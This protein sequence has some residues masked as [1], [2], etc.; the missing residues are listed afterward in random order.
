MKQWVG[1]VFQSAV[2]FVSEEDISA[3]TNWSERIK[4]ELAN[5]NIGI[6]CVT[7]ENQDAKWINFEMGALSKAVDGD[8]T[9]VI[10]TLIGF[11][12]LGQ[13]GQPASSFN[14]TMLDHQGLRSIA[15]SLNE[16]IDP[17]MK[18]EETKLA[19]VVDVW[20]GQFEDDF[21]AAIA[22]DPKTTTNVQDESQMIREILGTVR[23]LQKHGGVINSVQNFMYST[24]AS[25]RHDFALTG[26]MTKA[27]AIG[28]ISKYLA[29]NMG[30]IESTLEQKSD[31]VVVLTS[32]KP[33]TVKLQEGLQ[34]FVDRII[35][36]E[37]TFEFQVDP[38]VGGVKS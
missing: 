25:S 20:W 9:R 2:V 17:E 7:P 33:L 11:D 1:Q 6:I 35:D 13:L 3:G 26:G 28:V 34:E 15:K 5:T 8:N 21:A 19:S 36:D 10:P 23:E 16:V 37:I 31:G 12:N 30:H 29:K 4:M 24:P 38:D 32:S 14:M 22:I 18:R 27:D